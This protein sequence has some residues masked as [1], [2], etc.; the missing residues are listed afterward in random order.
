MKYLLP[1]LILLTALAIALSA[2]FFSV[3]GLAALFA[4]ASVS[5]MIMAGT[6]EVGKLVIASLLHQYWNAM[7]GLLKTYLTLATAVLMVIT[8]AGIYGFLS[9]GY[10]KTSN[11]LEVM[12]KQTAVLEMRKER[13]ESQVGL[14]EAE[15]E[16]L[17]TS[18]NE[19]T[20]GLSNNVI[21]YT[22][23]N[24]NVVTTTSS[25]TRRVLTEQL[26]ENKIQ[27]E[28]LD[29]KLEAYIDSISNIDNQIYLVESESVIAGELGPLKYIS[30]LTGNSMDS[31]VNWFMLLLIFV[32]DPLAVSLIIAANFAFS[33]ALGKKDPIVEKE[34]IEEK[35]EEID[36][37]PEPKSTRKLPKRRQPVSRRL[38]TQKRRVN[39][40]VDR[41]SVNENDKISKQVPEYTL[42]PPIYTPIREPI[43][44]ERIITPDNT[45]NETPK[46][47]NIKDKFGRFFVMPRKNS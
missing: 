26:E 32:F 22:D 31:I 23:A 7:N 43:I 21:Q 29:L 24:G 27:R 2:A 14:L 40:R 8:S 46:Q 42:R 45:A 4:G 35:I 6:L 18:I 19:L 17:N 25:A 12:E 11:Q 47:K 30:K 16:A 36:E 44:Q 38:P 1:T 28:K 9:N 5:V 10:S 37:Q 33:L 34:E 41:S 3:T 15:K 13:F 20:K 39:R